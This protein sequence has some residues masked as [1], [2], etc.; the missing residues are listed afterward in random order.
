VGLHSTQIELR[1]LISAR[2]VVRLRG[3]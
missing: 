1:A 2:P 3:A